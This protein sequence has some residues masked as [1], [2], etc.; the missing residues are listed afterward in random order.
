MESHIVALRRKISYSYVLLD[1]VEKEDYTRHQKTIKR[2]FEKQYGRATRNHLSRVLADLKHD[3][4]VESKKLCL[5][6]T[7]KG[8]SI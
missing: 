8:E 2:R 7:I 4:R 5:E 1:C 6:K 3:L